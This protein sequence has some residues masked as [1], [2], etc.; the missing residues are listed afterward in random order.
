MQETTLKNSSIHHREDYDAE[1]IPFEKLWEI[2]EKHFW[3]SARNAWIL[4][5][6]SKH[7]FKNTDHFLEVGCGGGAVAKAL[8]QL[9]TQYVGVDTNPP[10]IE[11]ALSRFPKA[12]FINQQLNNLN[13]KYEEQFTWV[14]FF[15]VL[16]HLEKPEE[17]I[18]ESLRF[19]KKGAKIIATVPAR[20][21]LFSLIDEGSGHKKRYEKNE[22]KQQLKQMGFKDVHEYGIFRWTVPLLKLQRHLIH[23]RYKNEKNEAGFSKALTENFKVPP[24]IINLMMEGMCQIELVCGGF[25]SENSLGASQIVVGTF[26]GKV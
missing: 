7:G 20:S 6:L 26:P 21:S 5:T 17:L 12:N 24:R 10:L 13:D 3:F 19:A 8:L 15:D 2:E 16:E 4:K 22:L 23:S 11:K 14:G 25:V 1:K 18:K 9:G